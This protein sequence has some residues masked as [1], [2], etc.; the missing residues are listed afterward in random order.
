MRD[1][2]VL[3]VAAMVAGGVLTVVPPAGAA[4][5]QDARQVSRAEAAGPINYSC[6]ARLRVTRQVPRSTWER[7]AGARGRRGAVHLYAAGGVYRGRDVWWAYGTGLRAGDRVSIDWTDDGGRTY[8][9]CHA[10]V[11]RGGRS[12][13]SFAVDDPG[14]RKFRACVKAAGRWSCTRGWWHTRAS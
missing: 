4:A 6:G 10:V 14:G 12:A 7:M 9:A 1:L 11:G 13:T 2:R 5:R 8:H 3:A